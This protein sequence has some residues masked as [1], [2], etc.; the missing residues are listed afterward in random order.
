M[1]VAAPAI[2]YAIVGWL[3]VAGAAAVVWGVA[4]AGKVKPPEAFGGSTSPRYGFGALTNTTTSELPVPIIYGRLKFYGNNIYQSDPGETIDKVVCLCMGEIESITEVKVNDV[5]IE[6][7]TGCT[8]DAYLGTSNQTIDSRLSGKVY[9]LRR[10]AYLALTLQ[11]SDKLRGGNPV[12]SSMVEGTKIR[13]WSG[14]QWSSEKTYSNNPAACVLD[15]LTNN[16]Y[17]CGLSDDVVD[18]TSFGNAY[19]YCNGQVDNN[20]GG[21]ENRFELDLAIDS[22]KPQLDILSE[23]LTTFGGFLVWS[24]GKIYLH[25]EKSEVAVQD[26]DEDTIIDNSVGYSLIGKD[27]LYNRVKILFMDPENEWT[28]V[29]AIAEDVNDQDL[30]QDLE[31]GRGVVSTEVSLLG[32]TRQ[33]QAL[34]MANFYLRLART[35]GVSLSF[36][37]SVLA[38][39]C[40]PGDVISVTLPDFNWSKKQFRI[41]SIRELENDEREIECREHFGSLYSDSYGGD[42]AY[43]VRPE[44]P[45]TD[46][47]T[48][49][50]PNP[51]D[52]VISET[53]YYNHDG[54]FISDIDVTWVGITKGLEYFHKYIVEVKKGSEEYTTVG[55]TTNNYFT[56]PNVESIAT[57][58]VR[59]KTSSTRSL[60]SSGAVSNLLTVLGETAA[61]GTVQGIDYDFTDELKLFWTPNTDVNLW[62]YEIRT[63]DAA[64][65]SGDTANLIFRG[66][67]SSFTIVNPGSRAPGTYYVRALNRSGVYSSASASVEPTNAA[68]AAPV[69]SSV[70]WFGYGELKWV[71]STDRDLQRYDIYGSR[72]AAWEAGDT[73]LESRVRGTRASVQGDS[74]IVGSGDSGGDTWLQSSKLVGSGDNRFTGDAIRIS[75]G[76]GVGQE[77][78]IVGYDPIIGRVSGDS[79]WDINPDSTSEWIITDKR[80]YKVYAVDTFGSGDASNVVDIHYR[81]LEEDQLGDE[82]IRARNIYAGEVITLTAQIRDAIIDNAKILNLHGDKITAGS[83][84]VSKLSGD[85]I[86]PKTYFQDAEPDSGMNE[87]DYWVDT[88]DDNELYIYEGAEWVKVS[89]TGSGGTGVTTFVQDE[90]PTATSIGDLWLDSNDSNKLY[91]ASATGTENWVLVRD[92]AATTVDT[93]RHSSDTTKIDGGDIYTGSV[94][95]DKIT[96]NQL[97]AVSANTGTLDVDEQIRVGSGDNV[98]VDGPSESFR[99]YSNTIAIETAINDKMDWLEN[100][101]GGDDT[102]AATLTSGDYV[103]GDLASELQTKM[104]AEGDNNTVV[105][106][107]S[108]ARKFSIA[109]AELTTL[110]LKWA[111]GTNTAKTCG[112]AFGFDITADDS[113]ALTYSGDSQ[114]TLRV[115]LGKLS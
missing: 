37:T 39:H 12:I 111:T 8:Y 1:P 3:F 56:I 83:I 102:Y 76:L 6:E 34:R 103:P 53:T 35:V 115:E 75:R 68:P 69:V 52:V 61:P 78:T 71:D 62:G 90:P 65:A 59:I 50:L 74:P 72:T 104:R 86:P 108:N 25:V 16:L 38:V 36:K 89:A 96:V 32:I 14:S 51:T 95:A 66:S 101:G 109:N 24:Q 43:Y 15:F 105:A 13:T 28:K 79:S 73:W 70:T 27:D 67:A 87:G 82:I 46:Y 77:K 100:D 106:W 97:D 49:P 9:G 29:Y 18:L 47:E 40:E 23:M 113:G 26:F 63:S 81:T 94:T 48:H 98:V 92:A 107:N 85:A 17:G 11:A 33:S 112:R 4:T 114:A 64:W 55:E 31:G 45:V 54:T 21:E 22:Y 93:W 41:L 42:L 30:R 99:V 44:T 58:Y 91:R 80:Y 7:L 88:D 10:F 60:V 5:A 20:D 84:T 57:Y 2:A 19:T 110:T